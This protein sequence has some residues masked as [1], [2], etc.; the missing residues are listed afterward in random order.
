MLFFKR[1]G[2]KHGPRRTAVPRARLGIEQLESRLVPYA[3]SGSAWP[4]SQ[5]VTLSFIPDGT[6][7]SSGSNGDQYSNLFAAFNA[8]WSTAT[9]QN[10]IIKAAQTWAQVTDLNFSVVGDNGITL[11]Q[12][13]YQQ[14]DPGMGDIRIGGYNF[15]ST[16]YLAGAYLPPPDNNYSI[17]GDI[18]FNTGKTFNIGSTYDL[19][20]VALHE[21]GHA[22]GMYHS[23]Y[24][25]A[26]MWPAYGGIRRSLTTDDRDGIRQIYGP[27]RSPD[28][29]DAVASND[30]FLTATPLTNLIDSTSLTALTPYLDITTTADMDYYTVVAPTLTSGTLRVNVQS[31]GL[32]LFRPAVSVYASDTLT[33]LASASSGTVYNGSTLSLT[34][35]NVSP[36]QQFYI[37]IDGA[38]NTA[39]GTGR[40]ALTLNFGTGS[41]PVVPLPDTRV[42]N[43][44]VLQG[45][46][47]QA[48][49]S[50]HFNG[51]EVLAIADRFIHD[52]DSDDAHHLDSGC[53]G[54]DPSFCPCCGGA[55]HGADLLG[56]HNGRQDA[57]RETFELYLEPPKEG[58][59]PSR[60]FDHSFGSGRTSRSGRLDDS[61]SNADQTPSATAH[62][63]YF[64]DLFRHE[65]AFIPE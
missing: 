49:D 45:G 35:N 55:V 14:G 48:E 24:S 13:D 2:R 11:G 47:A 53:G 8:R 60:G 31:R 56:G 28:L 46:G 58:R 21:F 27:G 22:L 54:H 51:M 6:L 20:T 4:H 61:G 1:W 57:S 43:G 52:H 29:Y 42:L 25:S 59:G 9:W 64:A 19:Q 36:L 17:A 33:L 15:G 23:Q 7:M 65:D 5:L 3:L 41:D 10:E 50:E 18:A 37:V 44:T 39:F 63:A 34:I 30:S 62:D 38:D 16:T 32:S 40:Y 26:V 12:G